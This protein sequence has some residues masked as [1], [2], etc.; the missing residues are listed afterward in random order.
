VTARGK[1]AVRS[2]Q[3]P[4]RPLQKPGDDRDYNGDDEEPQQDRDERRHGASEDPGCAILPQLPPIVR[5][6]SHDSGNPYR[7]RSC[8][9]ATDCC[10]LMLDRG[11]TEVLF[12][13]RTLGYPPI[14][15][16][17]VV[18]FEGG[19]EE[20]GT[21]LERTYPR[22]GVEALRPGASCGAALDA[23]LHSD[24]PRGGTSNRLGRD[25]PGGALPLCTG[26]THR[27]RG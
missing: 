11:P 5:L 17:H 26:S 1:S 19:R 16:S 24:G 20:R 21:S 23:C 6:S 7:Q 9:G 3:V 25:R 13:R 14:R 10:R 18:G 22:Q 8:G 27:L 4:P 15:V 12:G 2:V